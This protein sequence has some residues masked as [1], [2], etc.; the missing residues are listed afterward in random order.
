[1]EDLIMFL[2][3]LPVV[4]IFI[5][6]QS[7]K[8]FV[9]RKKHINS[10]KEISLSDIQIIEEIGIARMRMVSGKWESIPLEDYE[11]QCCNSNQ[12]IISGGISYSKNHIEIV[13][14]Y[15]GGEFMFNNHKY[16][17]TST[18]KGTIENIWIESD[19]LF[20]NDVNYTIKDNIAYRK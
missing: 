13:D 7:L 6:I 10:D 8:L 16:N 1:M 3:L 15:K 18:L 2:P 9:K 12:Y 5:F 19:D 11:E 4:I 17:F 14:L 20:F